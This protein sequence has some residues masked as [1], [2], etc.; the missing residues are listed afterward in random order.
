MADEKARRNRNGGKK[1][2]RG[3]ALSFGFAQPIRIYTQKLA[4]DFASIYVKENLRCANCSPQV[5][6]GSGE[7]R[8]HV[9][10]RTTAFRVRLVMTT[11]IR[12]RICQP[13]FPG[14][15]RLFSFVRIPVRT[16]RPSK[17]PKPEKVSCAAA[18]GAFGFPNPRWFSSRSRYD[19]FN[20]FTYINTIK[21]RRE[22]LTKRLFILIY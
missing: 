19:H 8:T 14:G 12:F 13:R 10:L 22:Q 17:P 1:K 15:G 21:G 3:S 5:F 7:I 2:N 9:P 4:D 18:S 6:G 11:S 20:T 16:G